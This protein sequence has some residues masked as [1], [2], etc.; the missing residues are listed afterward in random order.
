MK[1]LGHRGIRQE[2]KT[3]PYQNTLEAI[4]YAFENKADG[5]EIDVWLSKDKKLMVIH[6]DEIKIHSRSSKIK[7]TRSTYSEIKN[8]DLD[9][10]N[11]KSKIPSLQELLEILPENK[12]LNIEI[13]QKGIAENV[14][15]EIKNYK[16]KNN[17]IVSSFK[18]EELKTA[19]QKDKNIKLGI[20]FD[21][22]DADK[23]N[24]LDYLIKLDQEINSYCYIPNCY[25][26]NEK[27]LKSD[28]LK[29]FWTI[30]E[31]EIDDKIVDKLAK[32]PNSNFITDYPEILISYIKQNL[33]TI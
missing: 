5:I 8:I 18:H 16:N 4:N 7:I 25:T 30:K 12:I 32:L 20:L 28:K 21:S 2:D 26:T 3:K 24:F 6:D 22:K 11:I 19:Y 13:K 15:E 23:K 1:I 10:S 31:K 27:I 9:R 29:F 17:I 33:N 14:V